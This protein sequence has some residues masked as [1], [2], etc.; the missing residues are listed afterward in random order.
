M[1]RKRKFTMFFLICIVFGIIL[2]GGTQL[3]NDVPQYAT[4]IENR[5]EEQFIHDIWSGY[6]IEQSFISNHDFEFI[7]LEFSDHDMPIQGKT[8]FV[9]TQEESE[10][11]VCDEV[12]NNSEIHYSQ[13]VKLY[14]TGEGKK[15]V[16]YLITILSVDTDKT[17]ALGL[18]GYIPGD[19]G[20]DTCVINGQKS[21]YAVGVGT[22]KSTNSYRIH[23]VLILVVLSIMLVA[24]T[25]CLQYQAN[26]AIAFL[27]IAIPIGIIFLSF[28]NVNIV[29]DGSTH[30][31]NAYKY[32]NMIMGQDEKDEYGVVY[33][34]EGEIEL[35]KETDNLYLLLE[36]MRLS[37]ERDSKRLPYFEERATSADSILV[38]LPHVVGLTIGRLL[39]FS[40]M[41]SLMLAKLTGLLFYIVLC[42]LAIRTTPVLK[43]GFA[44]A[45][46]L[47]MNL[48]QATG[49]TYDAVITPVAYLAT[50]LILRGKQQSLSN[51]EQILLF[52]LSAFLGCSKG[53]IYIPILL[54]L[55]LIPSINL[56]GSK[57]KMRDSLI[58]WLVAGGSLILTYRKSFHDLFYVYEDVETVHNVV[59]GAEMTITPVYSLGYVFTNP[60]E[61][62]KLLVRTIIERMDYY[63]GS[64]IGNRMAWTDY[65]TNWLII[66]GF[67]VMLVL[68]VSWEK[69][70]GEI[71]AHSWERVVIGGIICCEI[72]GFHA[73]M[74]VETKVGASV[75]SG[76]Q[77]RYFLPFVPLAMFCTFSKSRS[78]TKNASDW[79]WCILAVLMTIYIFDIITI[80]YGI[81]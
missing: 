66:A 41:V 58:S 21:E 63:V 38:Y 68:A 7:T 57:K 15:N 19:K 26:P 69:S 80:V 9:I 31:T 46:V 76:V 16:K 39:R 50:A 29:H 45:A 42:V 3:Y 62:I 22:H 60:F 78:R 54:L 30:L 74:L 32:S 4:F 36:K 37:E 13:P 75:I 11:V 24:C 53:G 17:A 2:L 81:K 49:V 28:L 6:K 48:Y 67:I 20:Q 77:G 64:M 18:F 34:T 51:K 35:R 8:Q 10:Q 52:G 59:T 55:L 40:P 1:E 72:I 61:F 5:N 12:L 33:L 56:G 71:I 44:V 70:D 47:P 73:I 27:C 14:I 79:D 65:T 23:F 43:R 25:F